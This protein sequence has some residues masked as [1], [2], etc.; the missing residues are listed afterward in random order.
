MYENQKQFVQTKDELSHKVT[1]INK[2]PIRWN[3]KQLYYFGRINGTN[4]NTNDE[5][6]KWKL[7]SY[8][9]YEKKD[10]DGNKTG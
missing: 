10:G 8:T 1:Y 4:D 7:S 2:V 6:D 3:S 5:N 9:Y